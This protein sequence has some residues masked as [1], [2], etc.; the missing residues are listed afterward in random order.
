MKKVLTI[1]ISSILILASCSSKE[2]LDPETALLVLME[3]NIYPKSLNEDIYIGDPADAR[4]LLDAGLED[5][6]LIT[7]QRT[8]KLME[9]GEPLISFTE[10]AEPYL[11]PGKDD[12][13]QQIKIADEEIDQVTRV[14]MVEGEGRAVV[15]YTTTFKN[16]SPFS[17][18][19]KMEL[20]EGGVHKVDFVLYDDGW[21]IS[22]NDSSL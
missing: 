10:K 5:A 4:R 13:I 14:Q 20:N 12:R 7:V 16:I 21:K 3:Q 17:R 1:L 11:L 8:Q 6:G 9:V 22:Q 19:L 15:E 18:L 2:T